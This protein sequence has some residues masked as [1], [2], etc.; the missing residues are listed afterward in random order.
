MSIFSEEKYSPTRVC[1]A[2]F[3]KLDVS[4]PRCPDCRRSKLCDSENAVGRIK[5]RFAIWCFAFGAI[6]LVILTIYFR[7]AGFDAA[8]RSN[9]APFF[10]SM[11]WM[12]IG[13][14]L[15]FYIFGKRIMRTNILDEDEN[16]IFFV[17]E[18]VGIF[19]GVLAMALWFY[20][21]DQ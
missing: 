13:K 16:K 4:Y 2:C 8:I 14:G 7:N 18:M 21:R 5:V 10:G 9:V 12:L 3:R 15:A 17:L 20:I 11:A 6:P 1:E 19:S